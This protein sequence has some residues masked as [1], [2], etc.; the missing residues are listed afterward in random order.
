MVK[1][2]KVEMKYGTKKVVYLA[3]SPHLFGESDCKEDICQNHIANNVYGMDLFLL[4][5][6]LSS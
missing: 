4:K 5:L 1:L 6:H 3:N 2:V